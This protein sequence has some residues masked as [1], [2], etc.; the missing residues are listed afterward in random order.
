MP[1]KAFKKGTIFEVF[2]EY[3]YLL[4]RY[5]NVLKTLFTNQIRLKSFVYLSHVESVAL[6]VR[7]GKGN[8][9]GG[10]GLGSGTGE[11]NK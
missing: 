11:E 4:W 5:N 6:L 10:A 3:S 2:I 8:C 9:S 7:D 1:N